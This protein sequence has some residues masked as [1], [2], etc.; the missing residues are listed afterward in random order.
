M[1]EATEDFDYIVDEI[2]A[3]FSGRL[4]MLARRNA[5]KDAAVMHA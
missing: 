5:A 4:Q 2:A 1:R 3:I